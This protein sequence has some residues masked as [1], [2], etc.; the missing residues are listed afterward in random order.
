MSFA[1]IGVPSGRRTRDVEAGSNGGSG[2]NADMSEP[3]LLLPSSSGGGGGGDAGGDDARPAPS[4][5]ESAVAGAV[6]AAAAVFG[7][8]AAAA[9]S[10]AAASGRAPPPSAFDARHS[11]TARYRYDPP[12]LHDG[13]NGD[14]DEEQPQ[15][16][17]QNTSHR[18][19]QSDLL[20]CTTDHAD[21]DAALLVERTTEIADVH[22]SMSQIGAIQRDLA[23]LV[24]AQQDDVD[25]VEAHAE[26]SADYA[27][28]ARGELE[29]A[30][31][32]WRELG[33][34]QRRWVVRVVGSIVLLWVLVHH[35]HRARR[36]AANGDGD[37][38]E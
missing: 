20:H 24:E 13:S 9:S 29:R 3:L 27:G 11:S 7:G 16:Q 22:R 6:R 19:A 18:H 2:D 25:A 34:R 5:S 36:E 33:T 12:V 8:S 28:R 37:G 21:L 10:G 32:V 4:S 14:L 1:N 26:A 38:G 30:Y 35:L 15:H 17:P 31:G 23:T